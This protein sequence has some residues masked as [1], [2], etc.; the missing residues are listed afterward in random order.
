MMMAIRTSDVVTV[1]VVSTGR[2]G[3]RMVIMVVVVVRN[4][5]FH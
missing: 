4:V 1:A 2:G 3:G 5:E